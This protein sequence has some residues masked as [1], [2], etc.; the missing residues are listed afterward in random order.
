[1]KLNLNKVILSLITLLS[2][3][4]IF[5]SISIGMSWD[6][7]QH[8]FNGA[9]RANYLK[10][11]DFGKFEFS[12]GWAQFHP[13]LY[14]TFTFI[15]VDLLLKIFPEKLIE[16]RHL[17]NLF[18]SFLTLIGLFL[19]SKKNFNKEIAYLATFLCFINPFFFGHTAINPKDTIICFALIWFAYSVY[20]YCVNFDNKRL[21]FL[22]L[23]SFFMGFGLGTR[24]SFF[25]ITAPIVLSA[26]IFIIKN[27]NRYRDNKV[28][29]KIF[30]DIFI[31]GSIS[32]SLMILAWPYVHADFG[33]LL[34]TVINSTKWIAGPIFEMM[35]GNIFET[36][37]IPRTYFLSFFIF[38]IP[39]FTLILLFSLF[40]FLKMDRKFFSLKFSNFKNKIIVILCIIL[41]PMLLA[42]AM[43][44]KLYNG[45]RLF[46]FIIPFVSLLTAIC[47]YYI[48]ENFKKSIFIKSLLGIVAIFFLLFIQRFIYLTPYHYDYSN[49]L[50]PKFVNTQKLHIHDYWA[51]SYK[52]LMKLIGKN[53]NIKKINTDFCGGDPHGIKYLANKYSGGKVTFVPYEQADYI[54]MINTLSIHP[55]DNSTCFSARPGTNILEVKRLGVIFSVLRKLDK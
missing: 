3:F 20:M 48:L 44:V 4:A 13:G 54:I 45:I 24:A 41:F 35:N 39:I 26:L 34:E 11:F 43:Q 40:I 21:K 15:I 50:Y 42:T 1:M 19:I 18:F 17:I 31:F 16:I 49:F 9:I 47:F 5:C 14:D 55:D 23:A 37:N 33:V 10:S 51:T 46:L 27:K 38:R 29:K 52:E 25:V 28:F 8:H 22:I 12:G 2:L 32:F 6:E 53:S 36:T 30:F 7:P